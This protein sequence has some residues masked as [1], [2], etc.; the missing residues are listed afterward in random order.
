MDDYRL[1]LIKDEEYDS[2]DYIVLLNKNVNIQ[3]FREAV[4]KAR[5]AI[6]DSD[7]VY[8]CDYWEQICRYLGDYDFMTYPAPSDVVYY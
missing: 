6:A 8:D 4:H 1:V 2:L 7:Y 3:E 5:Q